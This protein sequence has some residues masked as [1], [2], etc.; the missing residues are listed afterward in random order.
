MSL[1]V[2]AI[3]SININNYNKQQNSVNS[4]PSFGGII[5]QKVIKFVDN[6]KVNL[7]HNALSLT[8]AAACASA[9]GQHP[10]IYI[11]FKAFAEIADV[12]FY[13]ADKSAS[14]KYG[15]KSD[16]KFSAS[17]FPL[18]ISAHI[19]DGIRAIG[20]SLEDETQDAAKAVSKGLQ[21]GTN[22]GKDYIVYTH[23]CK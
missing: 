19:A 23:K 3:S 12:L 2:S 9:H 8:T 21:E 15:I 16:I 1:S 5:P 7:A 22:A 10:L 18:D 17:H 11:S 4:Q 14:K 13:F 20:K 6:S